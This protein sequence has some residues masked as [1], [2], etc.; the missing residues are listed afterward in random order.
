MCT[1]S[2]HDRAGGYRIFFNRDE[3]RER[4]PELPPAV[5]ERNGSRFIAPRDGEAGGS[6]IAVNE[7]GV[8]LC[9]LNGF[10]DGA[11]VP[12]AAGRDYTS[13]GALPVSLIELHATSSI[14][15]R[16]RALDLRCYRPFQLVAFAPAG[17][18]LFADWSGTTLEIEENRPRTRPLVSSSF[19]TESVRDSR[20]AVYRE[21]VEGGEPGSPEAHR[22]FHA[23]HTP[24]RGPHSPCMHR[25][26]ART[27]S[28]SGISVDGEEV[29][30]YYAP[31]SPCRGLPEAPVLRIARRPLHAPTQ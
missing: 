9:L 26:D 17:S 3:R 5:D 30:F 28:F 18:G 19:Y 7:H 4:A 20:A 12:D 15:E 24:E 31:H 21:L 29:R 2:W 13:R 27:V 1:M 22:A 23:S 11:V 10:P 14:A 8:S 16:L 25:P 6:W